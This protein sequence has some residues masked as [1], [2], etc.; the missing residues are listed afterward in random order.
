MTPQIV[1]RQTYFPWRFDPKF[2]QGKSKLMFG[3]RTIDRERPQQTRYNY[4]GYASHVS[5]TVETFPV[6]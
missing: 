5:S 3:F 4:H 1:I 2:G 6:Y